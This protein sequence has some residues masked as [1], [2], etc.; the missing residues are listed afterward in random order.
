MAQA[1]LLDCRLNSDHGDFWNQSKQ[2]IFAIAGIKT[3]SPTHR[4]LL[5][6]AHGR[7]FRETFEK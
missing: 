4:M 1:L 5:T 2:I 3:K 7:E 6:S